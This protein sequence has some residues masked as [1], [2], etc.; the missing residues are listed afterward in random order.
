MTCNL[1]GGFVWLS[2]KLGIQER[3][4]HAENISQLE[5]EV[6]ESADR[7]KQALEANSELSEK[8]AREVV[9]RELA[10]HDAAEAGCQLGDLKAEM[11]RLVAENANLKKMVEERDEKLS[12]SADELATIQAAKEEAEAELLRNFEEIEEL[13]KQSFLRA[14][15]QAHVLYGGPSAFGDFDLDH[16][17]YQDRLMLSAEASALAAQE[18]ESTEAGE[19]EC[20]EGNQG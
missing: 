16:E 20:L 7:L 19:G 6:A 3:D 11:A 5:H 15:C 1:L 13:L 14:V 8:I 12:S 2:P 9:E 10:Q 18:V 17:V 4:R